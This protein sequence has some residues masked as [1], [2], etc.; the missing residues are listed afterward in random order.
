[1][2]AYANPAPGNFDSSN[3]LFFESISGKTQAFVESV[4]V[5]NPGTPTIPGGPPVVVTPD[6]S[7]AVMSGIG[8]LLLWVGMRQKKGVV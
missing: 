6:P 5:V 3:A 7:T 1:M 2:A 8:F 4:M